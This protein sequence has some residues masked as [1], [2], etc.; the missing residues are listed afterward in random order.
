MS[1]GYKS[2]SPLVW[3]SKNYEIIAMNSC[4]LCRVMYIVSSGPWRPSHRRDALVR[5]PFL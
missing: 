2:R 3:S 4:P 1:L 5:G